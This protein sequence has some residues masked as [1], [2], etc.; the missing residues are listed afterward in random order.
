MWVD[1]IPGEY[2][3]GDDAAALGACGTRAENDAAANLAFLAAAR[4]DMP[5]LLAEV[6]RLR[7]VE[8]ELSTLRGRLREEWRF[9][10]GMGDFTV[11][12]GRLSGADVQFLARTTGHPV[13]HRYISEWQD[14]AT[15]GG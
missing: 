10:D 11:K 1:N 3:D 6:D 14:A 2:E 5:A 15:G 7:E 9:N 8:T 4:Q 12:R 13:E